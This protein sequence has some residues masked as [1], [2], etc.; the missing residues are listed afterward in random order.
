MGAEKPPSLMVEATEQSLPGSKVRSV[1]R[2]VRQARRA[3]GGALGSL[4]PAGGNLLSSGSC[5]IISEAT[6]QIVLAIFQAL[7][8]DNRTPIVKLEPL[9]SQIPKNENVLLITDEEGYNL[10]QKAVGINHVDLVKWILAR[11][12]DVNRGSC[13]LPLHIACLKGHDEIVELLLR[14]NARIDADTKMCWPGPH[15]QNCEMR[16][17]CLIQCDDFAAERTS[18]KLQSSIFY[19]VDGDQVDTLE[20]LLQ[21]SEAHW[22]PWQQKRPLLHIACE[23]GAWNCVKYLV[24]ERPEEINQCY[25]EYYPLHQATQHETRFVELLVQ[26]GASTTVRTNTQQMTALHVLFLLGKRSAEDTLATAKFL[27]EHG[28]KELLNVPDSLGNTPLH[29]LIVRYALEE[30][31][32]GYGYGYSSSSRGEDPLPWNKWD[33][34][35]IV[36]YLIHQGAG[37]SINQPGNSALACVLRHVRDWEFRYELLDMLLQHGG[38]P[39][40]VGRDGSGPLMV[41]LVPLINKDPLYSLS[42]TTKVF[43]LN[44]V[45]LLCK[46]G[47]N[48]NRSSRTNLTP[49]HV[50]VFTACENIASNREEEKKQAFAFIRQLLIVLLQHGLEVNVKFSSRT[51]HV[52][53]SLLDMVQNARSPSDLDLVH[54]LTQTLIQYGADPNTYLS[55]T[56]PVVIY[57]SQSSVFLKRSLHLVLHHYVQALLKRDELLNDNNDYYLRL[58]DLYYNSMDHKP[59]YSCLKA[60]NSRVSIEVSSQK[61]SNFLHT[62][63]TNPRSLQQM[64][65]VAIYKSLDRRPAIY[66]SKVP[67]TRLPPSLK[68]YVLNFES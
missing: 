40:V 57:Q 47:A 54:Q 11:K 23:R 24:Y 15:T 43:Y 32:Y 55:T 37:P 4:F 6:N 26:C 39:N 49:L 16:F 13:S 3:M 51:E 8:V 50:L 52:L 60:L 20:L 5:K 45:R 53:L 35:H 41:C 42:H 22:L 67:V 36:R 27:L 19:A 28:L 18:D 1:C 14:H 9:L 56:E 65:R 48:T 12:P 44:C 30:G 29:A 61:L 25:D 63:Y 17:K 7:K 21:Q 38:D 2:C 33:M 58:I 66:L 46:H 31:R 64:C 10:L 62:L 68:S 34:L 59:L